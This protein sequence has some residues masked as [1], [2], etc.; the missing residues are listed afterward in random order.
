MFLCVIFSMVFCTLMWDW[1]TRCIA[2][3][4]GRSIMID[5]YA[6]SCKYH[7]LLIQMI[8][9]SMACIFVWH[10][11]NHRLCFRCN[12]C[13]SPRWKIWPLH[14][15]IHWAFI[16]QWNHCIVKHVKTIMGT[17]CKNINMFYHTFFCYIPSGRRNWHLIHRISCMALKCI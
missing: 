7:L 15:D 5:K 8:Y 13:A 17:C 12:I 3:Y 16:W 10:N 2:A 6:S 4:I 9:I 14:H 11:C 1:Y